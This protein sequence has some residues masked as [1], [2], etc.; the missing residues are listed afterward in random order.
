MTHKNFN[1]KRETWAYDYE[2][3]FE[4][5][6]R[7][8]SESVAN[9]FPDYNLDRVLRVDALDKAVGAILYQERPSYI[10]VV[11]ELIAF[12]RQ[13]F[14]NIASRWDAFK[15]EA[16]AAYYGVSHFAYYLRGK[17]IFLETDHRNLLWIEKSDV[18][19]VVRWRVFLQSHL[20][21]RAAG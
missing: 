8:L 19:I 11:H 10:G 15:K 17:P 9:H 14:S 4:K 16:Y 12:A 1:W 3:D 18:P 13:K 7:A 2:A 21:R 5:M 6:K 20:A